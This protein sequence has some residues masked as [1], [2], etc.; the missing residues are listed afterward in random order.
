MSDLTILALSGS[1]RKAS[2]NTRLLTAAQNVAPPELSFD[3][4]QDLAAIPPF[5][6]DE[7]HPAP[8]A[9]TDLRQRIHAA[10]GVLIATPEYNGSLPGVLKN[11][12]DWLSRPSDFGDVLNRKPVAIIGA[13]TSPIGTIR[14]QLN[15]R[16]VLHKMNAA[17]LGQPEFL[18]SLAHQHLTDSDALPEQ[19]TAILSNVLNGLSDLI[20]HQ[21]A[22]AALIAE[23][24]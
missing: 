10:D 24:N 4:F 9:V 2:L 13:S 19:A 20:R 5:N 12:L 22:V 17:V 3:R 16:V 18:L 6:E 15:L 23:A 11:A 7:E 8:A 14:A 21:H 1:L